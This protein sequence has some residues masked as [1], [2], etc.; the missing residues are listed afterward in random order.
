MTGASQSYSPRS[1]A[2]STSTANTQSSS[3][4]RAA[5]RPS[6]P[7]TPTPTLDQ[8]LAMSPEEISRLS[9]HN[10]KAVLFENH[11]SSG[12]VL[13]KSDL[14]AR[15][16]VLIDMEKRERERRR[17]VLEAERLAQVRAEEEAQIE[18]EAERERQR[19]LERQWEIDQMNEQMDEQVEWEAERQ[20]Q[21][22][23]EREWEADQ[24]NEQVE[25]EAERERERER[26]REWEA[27]QVNEQIEREAERELETE[28]IEAQ[29]ARDAERTIQTQ[30]ESRVRGKDE[31]MDEIYKLYRREMEE[32]KG[33]IQAISVE[34]V[35]EM[36][37]VG[38]KLKW[39]QILQ[40]ARGALEDRI[41]TMIQSEISQLTMQIEQSKREQLR[42]AGQ[43]ESNN[44]GLYNPTVGA[45]E[46][47]GQGRAIPER[48]TMAARLYRVTVESGSEGDEETDAVELNGSS[49][50]THDHETEMD[51][52]VETEPINSQTLPSQSTAGV[53]ANTDTNTNPSITTQ[54]GDS[55]LSDN[56]PGQNSHQSTT[57]ITSTS[58]NQSN[59]PQKPVPTTSIR[60]PKPVLPERNGL[61][62]VCQD[63]EA[64]IVIVDC[65]YVLQFLSLAFH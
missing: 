41:T 19:V 30:T 39:N 2:T 55:L 58:N 64:N 23:L 65:G 57:D 7:S 51:A 1:Y 38:M 44:D 59:N 21:R 46:S 22:E 16:R 10:L 36:R 17:E 56:H 31:L 62:I 50:T 6:A 40:R 37:L 43:S 63:E 8:L 4:P 54:T 42:Q 35:K 14:V 24:V 3:M 12:P 47:I 48:T 27:D 25:R 18:R 9:I 32:D 60:P 53:T 33:V 49:N 29:M 34:R 13:E 20:R 45:S 61:C 15:V 52:G 26:E 5:T 28:R 11:V